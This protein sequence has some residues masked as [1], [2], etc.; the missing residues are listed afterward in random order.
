MGKI[1]I[2]VGGSGQGLSAP[3]D[4]RFGR[5]PRFLVIDGDSGEILGTIGNPAADAAHGAGTGAASLMR[6]EEIKAVISGRFGPKAFDALNA[7]GIQAWI[8]P[9]GLTA[10]GALEA[11]RKGRL[12]RMEMKIYR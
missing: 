5:A 8:A 9:P 3:M 4:S 10:G 2:T 1:V 7:L 12:E 6:Q 11:F